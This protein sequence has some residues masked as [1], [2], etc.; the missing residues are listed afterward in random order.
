[1]AALSTTAAAVGRRQA[2]HN[3][4]AGEH[5]SIDREVTAHHKGTHSSILL[6]QQ[7]GLICQVCLVLSAVDKDETCIAAGVTVALVRGVCPSSAAAKAW[8][9]RHQLAI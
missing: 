9:R 5:A 7:V 1:M 6:G 3:A 2:L 4:V 8:K